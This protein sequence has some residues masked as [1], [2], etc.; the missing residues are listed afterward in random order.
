MCSLQTVQEL[1]C[2]NYDLFCS[3]PKFMERLA[4]LPGVQQVWLFL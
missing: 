3:D 2:N 4:K 1:F